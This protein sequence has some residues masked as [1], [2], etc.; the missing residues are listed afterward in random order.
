M[1]EPQTELLAAVARV[2]SIFDVLGINYLIG[3]S[4]AS[5]VFGE[6]RQTVDADLLAR[7]LGGHVQP[8]V[9]ALSGEFYLDRGAILSAIERQSSF[10]LIHLESMSKVDVFV[11]WRTP[12]GQS[13]FKRRQKI[14]LGELLSRQFFFATPE[15]TILAKLDWFKKGGAVSDRQWR[16]IL[17]VIKVQGERLDSDYLVRWANE[18]GVGD[19]LKRAF[20]EAGPS[21]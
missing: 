18:L 19:L 15:D 21:G 9:D 3:G 14:A 12:F 13:Q 1:S 7:V 4:M 11:S 16:D 8:L 6:P 10:N 2:V 17:G 5:S 20:Q